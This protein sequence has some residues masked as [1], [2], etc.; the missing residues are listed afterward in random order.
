MVLADPAIW[1]RSCLLTA[2]GGP[3]CC[4]QVPAFEA[5]SAGPRRSR[6]QVHISPLEPCDSAVLNFSC[7]VQNSHRLLQ[8]RKVITNHVPSR[9]QA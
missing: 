7:C 5:E 6:F 1:I 4:R 2:K 8:Q 9:S 3:K